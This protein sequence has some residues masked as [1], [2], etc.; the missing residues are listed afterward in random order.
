MGKITG[1]TAAYSDT[2][3]VD[4]V[5]VFTSNSTQVEH[6]GDVRIPSQSLGVVPK[7]VNLTLQ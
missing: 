1:L 6:F 5:K 7:K 2:V 4:W 3:A